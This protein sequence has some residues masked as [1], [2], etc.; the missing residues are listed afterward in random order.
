M[1]HKMKKKA[2]AD[3]CTMSLFGT[4][5]Q[6]VAEFSQSVIKISSL[7]EPADEL[8]AFDF[9]A[10][11]GAINVSPVISQ[12]QVA[13][14]QEQGTVAREDT[15]TAV[16]R[17]EP[18][19]RNTRNYR[20]STEGIPHGSMSVDARIEANI[21]ALKLRKQL[22]SEIREATQ[23]EKATL[24]RYSG[25][26]GLSK[27]FMS[28]GRYRQP[29]QELLTEQ[30]F[31]A[32]SAGMLTQHFTPDFVVDFVY[33]ALTKLGVKPR[34]MLDPSTGTGIFAARIPE[35][36]RDEV[37]I[38]GS[39]IDPVL[40]SIATTLLPD[41]TLRASAFES[42]RYP[43]NA[44]DLVVTNVPF[45]ATKTYDEE[46]P[47]QSFSLHNCFI[48]KALRKVRPG[49]VVAVVTS[50]FTLDSKD[51]KV[52]QMFA[53]T[54]DL[55][56]A[57]RLPDWVFQSTASTEVTSDVLIL[58]KRK[59]TDMVP[60]NQR[61]VDAEP[62]EKALLNN[63]LVDMP[64]WWLGERR[65][66]PGKF[67][68]RWVAVS[69]K[70]DIQ[71]HMQAWLD[72]LPENICATEEASV[73]QDAH[74]D[75]QIRHE[76]LRTLRPGSFAE[77][78]GQIVLVNERGDVEP[79]N[80]PDAKAQ[81]IRA[82]M[83][84]RETVK[85]LLTL[86]L[87][88]DDDAPVSSARYE[89]NVRYDAF[90]KA[91]KPINAGYNRSVLRDDPDFPLVSS[92]EE[93]DHDHEKFVKS[94]IMSER[95]LRPRKPVTH[96]DNAGDGLLAVLNEV[97]RVDMQR[98]AALCKQTVEQVQADLSA[99]GRIFMDPDT[100]EWELAEMYLSG[101]IAEKIEAAE[102]AALE[103]ARFEF[104]VQS[105]R[106]VLPERIEFKDIALQL[107][108]TVIT[109]KHIEQ[110]ID[111]LMENSGTT[112]AAAVHHSPSQAV[113]KV[114][115]S[116]VKF[117][118]DC[119]RWGT[120]RMSA[121]KLVELGLNMKTPTVRDPKIVGDKE[122]YVV[123]ADQ[124]LAAREKLFE[125]QEEF[126]SWIGRDEARVK[127]IEDTYNRVF[128]SSRPLCVDGGHLQL[129]G[130]NEAITLRPSQKNA[131]W[132]NL[133]GGNR[134]VAHC[135]GAGK[136]LVGICTVMEAKRLGIRRCSL[137]ATP[138]HITGQFAREFLKAYPY[139]SIL[140]VETD[141]GGKKARE[142]LLARVA[143][144]NYDA[145]IISHSAF[146]SFGVSREQ[147]DTVVRPWYT[148]INADQACATDRSQIKELERR[149]KVL[150]ELVKKTLARSAECPITFD[151]LGC[152]QVVV[153][154]SQCFKN[155]W[156]TTSMERVS[157][158]SSAASRRAFDMFVKVRAL[159]A[160]NGER[161]GAIFM[162][163]TPIA[164][165]LCEAYS[166]MRFMIMPTLIKLGIAQFD[167]WAANFGRTVVNAEPTPDGS[168]FRLQTRF[169][170]FENVPELM[171][172]FGQFADIQ[173]KEDLKLPV[174]KIA[175][176]KPSVIAVPGSPALK[177]Y[178][179]ELASR[180]EKIKSSDPEVRPHPSEDNMLK[181][182]T[183]GRL[184]AL[185]MRFVGGVDE[186]GSKLNVAID[187]IYKIW[188]D[189]QEKRLTQLVFCDIGTPGNERCD[190]YQDIKDKLVLRGVPA[191][192][193]A[194]CHDYDTPSKT[195]LLEAKM[196]RGD[197]RITVA[198]TE[199]FGTGK[200][201][202]RL[203]Y[204]EHELDCPWRPDQV[205]QRGG[206]IERQ[207]NLNPE[208]L[209]FRY[210]T[211]G[212][213]DSYNWTIV[214]AK[215]RFILQVLTSKCAVR[216]IED[217]EERALTV[218]EVKA[219]AAGNPLIIERA[220]L[221]QT[222]AKLSALSRAFY[223]EQR[224]MRLHIAE[225]ESAVVM[226]QQ[227]LEQVLEDVATAAANDSEEVIVISNR[228]YDCSDRQAVAD[229]LQGAFATVAAKASA[230]VRSAQ[231][232]LASAYQIGS[233]RGFKLGIATVR[234]ELNGVELVYEW[235]LEGRLRWGT[236]LGADWQGNFTRIKNLV[237]RLPSEADKRKA[238]IAEAEKEC[239]DIRAAGMATYPKAAELNTV[240]QKLRAIED[241]LGITALNAQASEAESS[242][243]LVEVD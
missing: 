225:R 114:V 7:P 69:A 165:S 85:R 56:A 90:V 196:N 112:P 79:L 123:N 220:V 141:G 5:D 82:Y 233:Y 118:N 156:F 161:G 117:G 189:T 239:S 178:V 104:N 76:H 243:E 73:A 6:E 223:S 84:I 166:L 222:E 61:W 213:F 206:R 74:I 188:F 217:I 226:R 51:T 88:S 44:F 162:S 54:A 10:F 33:A 60:I 181:V 23:A 134:L 147:L 179:Q 28:H 170:K 195:A 136:T 18:V 152:D 8:P 219:L 37:A 13:V 197:I 55:I 62:V 95:T 78:E 125:I 142:R 14:L 238:R 97:G 127:M 30:E 49:G 41:V 182:T 232:A 66:M 159:S 34:R 120:S 200:N 15:C 184:A 26:G 107:G 124:T 36:W 172:L 230:S 9:E 128:N 72:Q 237:N 194:F 87:A 203:L 150:D 185:D 11:L 100:R 108:S 209:M 22:L 174:P 94:P 91:Y 183:D 16:A 57:A 81:R 218:A 224:Q 39:E 205:E 157:G 240:R 149:K 137:I 89:L 236:E 59:D 42:V 190:I 68:P 40:A 92:L 63:A 180:A 210:V 86:Q 164:N 64:H 186:P 126:K 145:V 77:H 4:D 48:A 154:E 207:G 27:A 19:I 24:A 140:V 96:A 139:A 199:M 31:D 109:T 133:L 201:V 52:R 191:E 12:P 216:S 214:E 176:G 1:R 29:I 169:A 58:R 148:A 151:Q 43:D 25:W 208:I 65:S 135:V 129:P 38:Y 167:S 227:N 47:N 229:A 121:R 35:Q 122:K 46:V 106:A 101:N 221:Q 32:A 83:G 119:A 231:E 228:K 215:L 80:M 143:T 192:E 2:T 163:A 103:D 111:Y 234:N 177:A 67:G 144:G 116:G 53:D 45:D 113:W 3:F 130:L 70:E 160:K 102:M 211:T 235:C 21:E 158:L 153:D 132:G 168:G 212:S 93:Y 98:I 50:S 131:I 241:E 17:F 242:D 155:L 198:S 110:F 173:T 204:A 105:L 193:I 175:G 146:G 75:T 71:Q 115:P 171:A 202:Q 138:N 20:F 187:M 99:S